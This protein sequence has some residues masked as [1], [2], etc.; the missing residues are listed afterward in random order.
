MRDGAARFEV[1]SPTLIR[2]EYASDRAF[3]DRPTLTAIHRPV[4]GTR[5]KTRVD[6]AFR[7]IKTSRL[8]IRWRR[9]SGAFGPANLTLLLR[10]GG[11]QKVIHPRFPPPPGPAPEPPNPPVRTQA[12][13]NPD[14]D[15]GPRTKGNLGGWTRGVDDQE[16]PVPLHDGVLSRDGWYVMD[17][18]RSPLLTKTARGFATRPARKRTYQDGYLFAYGHKY[19]RALRDLRSLTGPAPLLPRKAFGNWFSRY[20]PYGAADFRAIV[21]RFRGERVPLD[22]LGIDTDFKAPVSRGAAVADLV[23]GIDQT[24]PYAWNGW[25]WNRDL[26]PQ[27]RAFVRWLHSKG[28]AVDLNVH[29]SI[30]DRDAHWAE[31][32]QRSGGLIQASPSCKYFEADP[33]EECAVFDWTRPRHRDAYFRLHAPFER[34]GIDFWWLDWCCDES[35]AHAPGMTE[36]TWINSRY[37]KRNFARGSRWPVFSRI[38]ASYWAYFGD[39]EPGA[40]AEHRQTIHFT[41][42]ARATWPMLDFET[43]VTAAEGA[44]IG[45]PYVSHDIGSFKGRHLADDMYVR[46][47][48]FG[49]LQPINR[50]HSDHGDRLP[51]EYAGKARAA[52]SRFLRL[53]GSLVPYLYTLARSAH[54]GGLPIVRA[55]YLQWPER[56][57]AY[58]RDRQYMLGRDLLVAPVARP[59]DPGRKTVWFPPGTWV[60]FFTGERH[61]GPRVETLSV[62]LERMPLFARA[63]AVLPMQD[64]SP[65]QPK[66]PPQRLTLNVWAGGDGGFRLY[67]D[68]GDGTA[69]KR[70]AFAFTRISHRGDSVTIDPARGRF[71]GQRAKRN[72]RLRLIGVPRP[73]RLTVNGKQTPFRYD[74]R[75]RTAVLSTGG[76]PT[77]RPVRIVL[78]H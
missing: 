49:A 4:R 26:F 63:G 64:Y 18:S 9:G 59:G 20:W 24:L 12:P 33:A 56:E 8:T 73:G 51:W 16:G 23:L 29:P 55:M 31:A 37:A 54:D 35:R 14:P 46:W 70:G 27:P 11:K 38:G 25:D 58:R 39:Q 62:P 48:Q 42:D 69:F 75:T 28:I 50:L 1:L 74:A 34:D 43:R 60:D 45:H 10:V 67:E 22:V 66:R 41:G 68:A 52:A 5:A 47:V 6:G 71:P 78:A 57:G 3:E 65:Q 40:F 32:Q 13:P 76:R 61:V 36:D 21:A 2:L 53:R 30:G 44:G 77:A 19:A 15:P 17:D 7:V 72:W